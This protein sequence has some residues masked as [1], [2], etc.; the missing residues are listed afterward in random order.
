M[1]NENGWLVPILETDQREYFP[2][3]P[4]P[5]YAQRLADEHFPGHE[6]TEISLDEFFTGWVPKL[7]RDKVKVG[8]F[9]NSDWSIWVMEPAELALCLEDELSQ[10][11]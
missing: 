9:P 11:Q 7:E 5:E 1:K 10:Y 8:V 6:A 4:H 2:V 3:W